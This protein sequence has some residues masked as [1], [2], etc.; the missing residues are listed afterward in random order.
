ME[1][2]DLLPQQLLYEGTANETDFFVPEICDLN[3]VLKV[4]SREYVSN[5]LNLTIDSRAAVSTIS[6]FSRTGLRIA[7]GTIIGCEKSILTVR[8][9][10]GC[11]RN[12]IFMHLLWRSIL[13]VKTTKQ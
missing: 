4:H 9:D 2:Y 5:L 11:R 10:I 6:S 3:I 12:T 8:S 7:N 13:H 1:K